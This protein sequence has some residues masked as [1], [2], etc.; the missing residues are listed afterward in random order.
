MT[1]K[2]EQFMRV[3]LKE[4]QKAYK[5]GEV[6]VGAVIVYNDAVV[7][8]AYNRPIHLKDPTAHAEILAIRKACRKVGNYRLIDAVLY[9]T[10]EPCIMCAGAILQARIK[11]VVYGA[12]DP[13]NGAVE[14]LYQLFN[15]KR[16]N[17][18]V[19]ITGGVLK[20]S[21]AEILHRFFWEKRIIS[22]SASTG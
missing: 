3:A 15:D 8:Q 11:H 14:S 21:C 4:A 16:F 10:L 20:E 6:P 2:N 9:T 17:H 12:E 22:R 18:T 1:E 7:S 13:K 5:H 19:E